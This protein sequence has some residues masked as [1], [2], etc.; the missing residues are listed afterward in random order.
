MHLPPIHKER[1]TLH[2]AKSLDKAYNSHVA[3]IRE[4]IVCIHL[5][6]DRHLDTYMYTFLFEDAYEL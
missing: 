1:N 3:H 6:V 4:R 5:N 2:I